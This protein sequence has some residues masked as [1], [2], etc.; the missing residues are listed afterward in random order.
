MVRISQIQ[1]CKAFCSGQERSVRRVSDAATMS[2]TRLRAFGIARSTPKNRKPEANY[3]DSITW[4]RVKATPRNKTPG[5]LHRPSNTF[6]NWSAPSIRITLTSQQQR[7]VPSNSFQRW[8]G[9]VSSPQLPNES[10]ADQPKP[11]ALV[12]AL[13]RAELLI[14]TSF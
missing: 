2:S 6:G 9:P 8:H 1:L 10:G 5:S 4:C 14:F 7:T 11:T 12:S 13:K 3:R